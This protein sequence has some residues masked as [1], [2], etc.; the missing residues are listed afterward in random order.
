M[1]PPIDA[2]E[3]TT[4]PKLL[5]RGLEDRR[6]ALA[7]FQLKRK[8][9]DRAACDDVDLR[10]NRPLNPYEGDWEAAIALAKRA[11]AAARLVGFCL[12]HHAAIK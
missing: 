8:R 6:E 10:D 9:L 11:T 7:D 12:A 4:W 3:E 2:D 1:R 5:L